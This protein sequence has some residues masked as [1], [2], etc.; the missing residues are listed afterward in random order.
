MKTTAASLLQPDGERLL[1][2]KVTREWIDNLPENDWRHHKQENHRWPPCSAAQA[3]TIPALF[4]KLRVIAEPSGHTVSQLAVAWTL[5]RPRSPRPSS[6]HGEGP[7]Y[8]NRS[9]RQWP[10]GQTEL[11]DITTAYDAFR[12]A[13]D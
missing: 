8:P 13:I 1:T 2:G 7:D 6:E 9:C 5:R 11:D 3:R 12:Q 4:E 10:L